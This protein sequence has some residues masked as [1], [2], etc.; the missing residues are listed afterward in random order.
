MIVN[1]AIRALIRDNKTHQV[2]SI[3]QTSGGIGMK[4]MNQSIFELYRAGMIS[5]DD[6]LANSTDQT[7]LQR[8]LQRTPSS[9]TAPRSV[10]VGGVKRRR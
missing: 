7:E 3:I 5:Y 6:A 9:G 2:G 4:T 1:P 10:A 8:L